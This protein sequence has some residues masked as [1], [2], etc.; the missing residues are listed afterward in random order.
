V[1][2]G[3]A[4]RFFLLQ[5]GW[6][7]GMTHQEAE[8]IF[9]EAERMASN[10]G[11]L[12]TRVLLLAS[13]AALR[14]INDGDARAMVDLASQA[15]ALAEET[16]DP[17]LYM[18]IAGNSYGYF[19]VGE[20]RRAVA[21]LDRAMELVGHDPDVAAVGSVVCPYGSA[22]IFK[23]GYLVALGEFEGT[24]ALFERGIELCRER[25]DIESI[26]WAH[27][28]WF[29]HCYHAGEPDAALGH[30]QQALD[31]SDRLGAAFSRIWSWTFF[32]GAQV[33]Q[34]RW[35]EAIESLEKALEI[36]HELQTSV[37]SRSWAVLWLAEAHTG[38]G[39]MERG[40]ELAR[41]ALEEATAR[42]VVYGETTGHLVLARLLLAASGAEAAEEIESELA[43]ANEQS[44]RMEFRPVT[45]MVQV[46]L[47][48]LAQARGEAEEHLKGLR[49]AHELFTEIGAA[50]H[51]D[52][53]AGELA[54]QR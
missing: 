41:R 11:D 39:E 32:G 15:L 42:G 51:A 2:L 44:R 26:G 4:A 3:L 23:G 22:L 13:Y 34:G 18:A 49:E 21:I 31:L 52:Q 43:V 46:E 12:N 6:R 20:H 37:E 54:L 1:A 19:L 25:G 16:E 10:A 48:K 8:R 7:L 45:A 47:A 38:L 27:M 40:V 9:T 35:S 53:V 36:S 5:F 50:G 29:W 24:P 14:G 30:A 17:M 28:W 33:L